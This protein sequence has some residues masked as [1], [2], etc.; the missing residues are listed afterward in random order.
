MP[1]SLI[2]VV[3]GASRLDALRFEVSEPADQG[4]P[5]I[6]APSFALW[7]LPRS[8]R[9]ELWAAW[10]ALAA[11]QRWDAT[12]LE[13]VLVVL[14]A[15]V[16]AT[17][18]PGDL[19]ALAAAAYQ[20]PPPRATAAHPRAFRGTKARP[21]RPRQPKAIDLRPYLLTRKHIDQVLGLL[22]APQLA[23]PYLAW[24]H[25]LDTRAGLEPTFVMYL[26]PL[27]TRCTWSEV[28]AF[29]ALARAASLQE[30][31][32]LRAA[33]VSVYLAAEEPARA[34]GWWSYVLAYGAADRLEAANLIAT[35]GVARLP[36]IDPSLS[37]TLA[38]LPAVQRWVGYRG[39]VS[40]ASPAYLEAGIRLEAL[41]RCPLVGPPPGRMDVSGLIQ[42]TIARLGEAMNS[43]SGA[44]FWR[45][46][47][48]T[49]CGE[50]SELTE[51]LAD[52]TFAA[53]APEAAFT[54]LRLATAPHWTPETAAQE[55]ST[56]VP[57]LP[58]LAQR[59]AQLSCEY[60]PKFIE[61][62]RRVYFLAERGAESVGAC[63]E[64]A[65]LLARPPF[66]TK[67]VAAPA[68]LS[69]TF[70]EQSPREAFRTA[71]HKAPTSSWLALESACERLNQAR[72]LGRGLELLARHL[73]Q[74]V[75]ATFAT[76][77]GPLLQT[78]RELRSLS[79]ED[80][81][82]VLAEYA[83][84][85]LADPRAD[86]APLARLVEL[87]EPIATAAGPNPIRRALR[88]HLRG[89]AHLSEA[90]LEGHRQRLLATLGQVRL[91]AIRQTL[92][93]RLAAR[94]QVPKLET[95]AARHAAA[96]LGRVEE[97][98]RQLRR[99][100]TAALSG[101]RQWRLRHPRTLE[102]FTRHPTIDRDLWL[103]GIE[104][105]G[106]LDGIGALRL[107]IEDDPLETLK[108]GTYVGTCLGHGGGLE[109][110]AA[111]VTLDVN[112]QV[113]YARD[114]HGTVVGRQLLALS[115]QEQLVC[116]EIYGTIAPALLKPLFL[117]YDRTLAAKLRLPLH[118]A[119]PD[120]PYDIA[121]ILSQEWWDDTAIAIPPTDPAEKT[122]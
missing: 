56:L 32:A 17:E 45:T 15:T 115:E 53:L 107:A 65:F 57:L 114:P 102:W 118:N 33:L 81:A 89:E 13:H 95:S 21:P 117:Q 44:E 51:L 103:T 76:A 42:D 87:I 22:G 109:Y 47:L 10:D 106:H 111:A 91:A 78:A 7:P 72:L 88:R 98:R 48:W 49:L 104:T 52:A 82:L 41:A 39:L 55:W 27:L 84:R 4:A 20:P 50:R 101:D 38:S 36:P 113:V 92:E 6:V 1:A 59:A 69:L 83:S 67:S 58:R 66:G 119:D 68:L 116:F 70:L 60:Q 18:D 105:H 112:K 64:L 43:D 85:P 97:N 108:L 12:T 28:G 120:Q 73:P 77:P 61:E 79:P 100:L 71:V 99:L 26:L 9:P 35:S 86:E 94:L 63:M 23:D 74:L 96:I 46:Y 14:R 37:A 80:A 19:P 121:T 3:R 62:L 8:A 31:P 34:L 40:G 24:H 25:Q 2:G 54:L 75:A 11:V 93:Q 5:W 90:Q 30:Q 29:A 16:P 110:S 122:P